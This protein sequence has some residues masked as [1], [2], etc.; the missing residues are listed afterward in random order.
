M[1]DLADQIAERLRPVYEHDFR[2][3]PE[4]ELHRRAAGGR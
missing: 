4:N 3:L 1:E 2:N